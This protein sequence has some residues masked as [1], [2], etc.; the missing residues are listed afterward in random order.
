MF[1]TMLGLSTVPVL[2]SGAF[3]GNLDLG[4]PQSEFGSSEREGYVVR[5]S[6]DFEMSVM[7][8]HSFKWVRSGHVQPGID[9]WSK[10]LSRN[11][12]VKNAR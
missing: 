10:N 4:G 12:T 7:D 3:M 6:G 1:A 5:H 8:R 9:H 2:Y 11:R